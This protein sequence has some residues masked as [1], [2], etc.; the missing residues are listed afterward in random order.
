MLHH[1]CDVSYEED[2]CEPIRTRKCRSTNLW[3]T[4]VTFQSK[5]LVKPWISIEILGI[6]N[7]KF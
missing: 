6:S 1:V 2:M 5:Y 7:Q 3:N 4:T